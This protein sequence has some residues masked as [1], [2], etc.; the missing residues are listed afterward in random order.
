[1]SAVHDWLFS[2]IHSYSPHLKAVLPQPED[3]P[4]RGDSDPL[5]M[6][7]PQEENWCV[8]LMS[9]AVVTACTCDLKFVEGI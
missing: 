7:V 6:C 1:L 4:Y 5:T 3:A 8:R 9:F 2:D